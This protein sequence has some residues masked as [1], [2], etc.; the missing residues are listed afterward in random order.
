MNTALRK[1]L[2]LQAASLALV[3]LLVACTSN[4]P[5]EPRQNPPPAPTPPPATTYN[6]SV[7]A[8]P[9]SLPAGSLD[10]ATIT[11]RVTRRDNGSPPPTGTTAVVSTTL[12]E[13]GTRGSGL[14]NG[15]VELA[16]GVASFSLFAGDSPGVAVVQAQLENSFGRANVN[17]GE[18]SP[19]FLSFTSPNTGS[20]QGGDVVDIVG[21]G[22]EEPVRVTFA[23]VVAQVRSVNPNRISVLTPASSSQV[24]VGT[25]RPVTVEV[26]IRLNTTESATD[27]LASGFS[28]VPGGGGNPE[29]PQVFSVSPTTGPNEG[30]TRVTIVGD[31]FVQPVQVLFGSGGAD[32]FNGVEATVESVTRTQIVVRTPAATGFGQAN[33]NQLVNILVRNLN[34]GF[35][36]VRTAAFR[37]GTSIVITAFSPP[38]MLYNA[39][40]TMTI[41]GQGFEAPVQ[42]F[43]AGIPAEPISV[44]GSQIVLRP[45][46]PATPSCNDIT[47]PV[48]VV[49]IN[50]GATT[51]STVA[52]LPDFIYR[53]PTPVVAALNPASGRGDVNN[54]VIVSGTGFLSPV[55]V[56]FGDAAG[57]NPVANGSGTQINVST[58]IFTGFDEQSCDDDGDGTQ[59]MKFVATSV[60]VKVINLATTCEVTLPGG[61]TFLPPLV[62]PCRGDDGTPTLPQCSDTFDNDGDG[63]ID[64]MD[65]QCTGPNDNDE[66][67]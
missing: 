51:N 41:F 14:Q 32:S 44:S 67:T 9:A 3:G 45:G 1:A 27:S 52:G 24:P 37:F 35:S 30:G 57:L 17:I 16:N 29:Q 56:I 61:F 47:G 11:V 60:D 10:A 8:D 40:A 6:I 2:L 26:T 22:F 23:G 43:V 64:N 49:N 12:G 7:T 25:T 33:Q 54:P 62:N 28:Y 31:G 18:A 55:R 13:L 53:V 39:Q 21:G 58:P 4:S 38:Q 15:V 63:L 42:V 36:T 46:V 65:P 48:Q 5:S 66:S 20:P 19:F 50:S 59:G 34:T